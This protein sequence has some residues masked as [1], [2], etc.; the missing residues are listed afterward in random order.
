MVFSTS[1]AC[2]SA[3]T[4]NTIPARALCIFFPL[5]ARF[6]QGPRPA[7]GGHEHH[8]S[9]GHRK[10]ASRDP[11]IDCD[12]GQITARRYPEH[13]QSEVRGKDAAA[14]TIGSVNL[15]QG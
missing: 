11:P 10:G 7:R 12:T 14:K 3:M 9:D 2:A 13:T 8:H 1:G 15:K 6:L 4:A 5:Y